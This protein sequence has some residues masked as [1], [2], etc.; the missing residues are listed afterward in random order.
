MSE[1]SSISRP[2]LVTSKIILSLVPHLN[3]LHSE[4][5]ISINIIIITINTVI[6]VTLG[7]HNCSYRS[8][9][10]YSECPCFFLSLCGSNAFGM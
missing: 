3:A 6:I 5:G 2:G 1:I 7:C 8:R 4:Y 9:F 10:C